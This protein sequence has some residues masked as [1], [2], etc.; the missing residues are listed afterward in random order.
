MKPN[1]QALAHI[2]LS[3]INRLEKEF[4]EHQEAWRVNNHAQAAEIDRL[5]KALA[6]AAAEGEK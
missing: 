1:T 3:M 5:R 6:D 2:R 4:R